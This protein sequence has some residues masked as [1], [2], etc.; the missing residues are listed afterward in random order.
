MLDKLN[1]AREKYEKKAQYFDKIG[2]DN[3]KTDFQEMADLLNEV[4]EETPSKDPEPES[5]EEAKKDDT[6]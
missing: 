1:K 5:A 3:L 4:I 6:V 2:F